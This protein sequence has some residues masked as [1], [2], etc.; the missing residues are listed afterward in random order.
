MTEDER[1]DYM[2]RYRKAKGYGKRNTNIARYIEQKKII[3][4]NTMIVR[5]QRCKWHRCNKIL[6]MTEKLYGNNC[7]KHSLGQTQNI[8]H[9][10]QL[11]K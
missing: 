11:Y 5:V 1:K 3:D 8:Y 2:L 7:A 9:Q 4:E 10:D 6:T